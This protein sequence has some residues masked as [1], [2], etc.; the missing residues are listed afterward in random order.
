MIFSSI[1]KK[2]NVLIKPKKEGKSNLDNSEYIDVFFIQIGFVFH[3]PNRIRRCLIYNINRGVY[4][5]MFNETQ[6]PNGNSRQ[7]GEDRVVKADKLQ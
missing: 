3:N 6:R 1:Y 7:S 5:K 2:E 4:R